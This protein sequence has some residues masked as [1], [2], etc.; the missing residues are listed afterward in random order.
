MIARKKAENYGCLQGFQV[1]H[2]L[3]EMGSKV[4]IGS[5]ASPSQS[6]MVLRH[7]CSLEDTDTYESLQR[8]LVISEF[9]LYWGITFS[10]AIDLR[11]TNLH[12]G[13]IMSE[14]IFVEAYHFA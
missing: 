11:D 2:S 9:A 1:H 4:V 7:S 14:R 10:L 6:M 5:G 3:V 12:R 13:M 8:S